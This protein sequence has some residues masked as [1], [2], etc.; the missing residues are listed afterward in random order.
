MNIVFEAMLFAAEVHKDQKRKF[1]GNPYFDHLS[2]VA[3]IT[4]ATCPG[5]G[6]A[7]A[8]A[9]LH[10]TIEDQGISG[11]E[12]GAKFGALV[13]K[14]VEA[15]TD[16]ETGS[17]AERKRLSRERLSK[18]PGWIQDIKVADIISNCSSVAV[19]DAEFAEIYLTEKRLMLDV[20]Q[21]ANPD[22][23]NFAR[24]IVG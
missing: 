2:E 10:D 1:T 19:H 6:V 12:I 16:S 18:K 21:S 22:L 23:V 24:K 5:M 17:R 14:G 13:R 3:G 11:T 4:A 9:W 15:L 20:L 7:I 8:V